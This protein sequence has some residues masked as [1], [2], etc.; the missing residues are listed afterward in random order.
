[1]ACDT[2]LCPVPAVPDCYNAPDLVPCAAEEW[3]MLNHWEIWDTA[4][5]IGGHTSM[6]Q[7]E[8][9]TDFN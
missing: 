2:V 5:G 6:G 9:C 7:M 1:M 4:A 8:F 3:C